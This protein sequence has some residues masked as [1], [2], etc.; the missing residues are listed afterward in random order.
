MKKTI[1]FYIASISFKIAYFIIKLFVKTKDDNVLFIYGFKDSYKEFEEQLKE[2]YELNYI[3]NQNYSFLFISDITKIARAKY[4]FLDD[5]CHLLTY[6]PIKN[7]IVTLYWH[8]NA[9]IKNIYKLRNNYYETESK[10]VI[11]CQDDF[12]SRLSYISVGSDSMA[13]VFIEGF[14]ISND[15]IINTGYPGVSIYYGND[16]L[17]K[18]KD[19]KKQ[20]NLGDKNILYIPTFR[21]DEIDND[22][23]IMFLNKLI[24][25]LGDEYNIYY[26]LHQLNNSKI[27]INEKGKLIEKN[28]EKYLYSYFNY[29]I[30]DYSSV[31]T[32]AAKFNCNMLFYLHDFD[33][34]IS[35]YGL[36]MAVEELPGFNSINDFEIINFIKKEKKNNEKNEAFFNTWNMYNDLDTVKRIIET[37]IRRDNA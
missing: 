8:A 11:K 23:N 19:I 5:R 20:Y 28:D 35:H 27:K 31:I 29:V 7:K 15:K 32:E 6:I 25:E 24:E 30:S 36:T 12:V 2:D 18:S 13:K 16:Y 17:G 9:A 37:V 34:Y 21:N 33:K 3:Y 4:I 10:T 14:G 22:E 1:I 26:K